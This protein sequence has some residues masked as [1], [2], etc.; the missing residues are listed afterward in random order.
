[1]GLLDA[2]ALADALSTHPDPAK[3]TA[4][5]GRARRRHVWLYQT[6]SWLFT[7]LYQSDSRVLPWIRDWLA[8]P[9]ARM[10]PAPPILARLIAGTLVKP[11]R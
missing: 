3:A 7:P 5:Y 2:A 9:A 8:A 6:A 11:I 10:P 1:M 4:V